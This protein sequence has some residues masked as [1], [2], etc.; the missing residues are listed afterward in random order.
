MVDALAMGGRIDEAHDLFERVCGYA[1]NL[2]LFSEE[3]HS[4][5]G[6]FLGNF[7][8][9]FTHM[10]LINSAVNLAKVTKHGPEEE[11]ETETQRTGRAGRAA[12]ERYRR[13]SRKR[14]P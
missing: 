11:P 8:Q 2:G 1:S 6:G 3:I 13:R 12:S 9:G 14:E 7:P 4:E 5:T 10:A